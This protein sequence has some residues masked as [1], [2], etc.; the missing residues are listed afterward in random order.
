MRRRSFLYSA[1]STP[2]LARLGSAAT[3]EPKTRSPLP[4]LSPAQL[5]RA[6]RLHRE[7]VVI[8]IHDHTW[9]LQDYGDMWKGGVTAKTYKPLA[10]GLY[11]TNAVTEVA[12]GDGARLEHYRLQRESRQAYQVATT[13]ATQGRDSVLRLHPIALGGGLARH[14]VHTVLTPRWK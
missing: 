7:A 14:D 6:A 9:R 8:D 10:D 11:W 5:E 3:A 4:G 12:V 1:L 2:V 13:H